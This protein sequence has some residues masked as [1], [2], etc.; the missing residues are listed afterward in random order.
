M[1]KKKVLFLGAFQEPGG[2]E[3]VITYLY[4]HL[5]RTRFEPFLCGPF[6]S[7]F[8][9]KHGIGREEILELDM[10]G[11][12]DIASMRKLAGYIDRYGIDL[13]HSH[14]NRGGLF[15]RVST[16]L[17]KTRPVSVWTCHLLI[18]ENDYTLSKLRK[19]IYSNVEYFLSNRMTD[20][21]VT[22]S[23]DLQT[24]YGAHCSSR[25]ITTIHNGIDTTKYYGEKPLADRKKT[26][27]FGFVSRMSKQKGLPYLIEGWKKL[28]DRY[29][30]ADVTLKL[31][32][33]G[34]GE[35]EQ[36]TKE[37]VRQY[38]LEDTV[39]FLGF[40]KDIPELLNRIDVLVLPSLFEGLPM[41]V[42]E[43]LCS[44]TPV[45]ASRVNGV[46]EVIEDKHNG[47]LV[48]PRHVDE[49]A[50]AMAYYVEEP[51]RIAL[52]GARGQELV[53]GQFTKEAMLNKHAQLYSVL[54]EE[55]GRA[56]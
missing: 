13:V 10:N 4:K 18:E 36:P 39:T 11:M 31:V 40:R 56:I 42:L 28:T 54:L 37:L 25:K 50:E 52:H 19:K 38:G 35:E 9:D 17:S 27:T 47:R 15:G 1:L 5:D 26:F 41:I 24:K 49:L 43:S 23:N 32:L 8:F 33:A 51:D 7:E 12:T 2:E 34:S 30:D 6:R 53:T 21:V 29:K 45:V 46:P 14:G 48:T 55:R 20:H 3:E 44:G 16:F 22:V